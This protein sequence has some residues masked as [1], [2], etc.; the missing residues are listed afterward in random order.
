MLVHA[1]YVLKSYPIQLE[2]YDTHS[3]RTNSFFYRKVLILGPFGTNQSTFTSHKNMSQYEKIRKV[4]L[5]ILKANK[6]LYNELYKN[7]FLMKEY[8]I[9]YSI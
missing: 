6:V 4:S 8:L 5:N 3:T 7:S 2:F 9:V 1:M